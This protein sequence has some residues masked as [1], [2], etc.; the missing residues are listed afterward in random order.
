MQTCELVL[1]DNLKFK[2]VDNR[3]DLSYTMHYRWIDE[4]KI[5]CILK[6]NGLVTKKT[7]GTESKKVKTSRKKIHI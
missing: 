1:K 5:E 7:K 2:S 4:Y 3:M 6:K